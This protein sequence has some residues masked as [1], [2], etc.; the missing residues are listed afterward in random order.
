MC[1]VP[2]CERDSESEHEDEWDDKTNSIIRAKW[3]MDSAKTLDEC[4]EK[5]HAYISYIQALKQ[6]GWELTQP[7]EDDYGFIRKQAS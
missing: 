4:I 1:A 6:D 7:V 2:Y 3:C 5:L